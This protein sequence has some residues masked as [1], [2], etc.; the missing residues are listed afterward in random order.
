MTFTEYLSQTEP[1]KLPIW[2]VLVTKQDCDYFL[3]LHDTIEITL[4]INNTFHKY[5][6]LPGKPYLYFHDLITG[7]PRSSVFIYQKEIS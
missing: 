1:K 6:T 3:Q 7:E 2:S 4:N 5:F